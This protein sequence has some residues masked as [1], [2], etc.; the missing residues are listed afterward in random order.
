MGSKNKH[1]ISSIAGVIIFYVLVKAAI[2]TGLLNPYWQ[3]VLDQSMIYVIGALGLSLIFGFTGQFSIGHAAFYGLG[4]YS[5]GLTGKMLGT[6]GIPSFLLALLVGT[7]FTALVAYLIGKPVLRLQSDYLGIATLGF[8]VIVKVALD[9]GNRLIPE[10]G[11]AT[12][13]TGVPQVATF[14][15]VLLFT[16]LAIIISRNFLHSTYGRVCTSIREDEIATKAVGINPAKYKMLVFVFGCALAG[17]AG[18]I[19]AH[20]YPFLHPSSFDFLQSFNF[21]IIVVAGGMGSL[22]G[23]VVTAVGWVFLQEGLRFMLGEAFMDWRG[24]IYALLLIILV[25]VRRQGLFGNKEIGFLTPQAVLT[26]GGKQ[27]VTSQS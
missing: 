26:K 13:M 10:L 5:A 14:E 9:N 20:R 2:V 7:L 8:G 24:V 22:T 23:T 15:W 12:G 19:Y 17:L 1:L 6:G 18:A 3:R 16:L 4:A 11:G 21:L 25:L 27:N